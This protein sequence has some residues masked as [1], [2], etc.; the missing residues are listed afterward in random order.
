M[1]TAAFIIHKA[2]KT[3]LSIDGLVEKW[4]V[5]SR[6]PLLSEDRARL[7]KLS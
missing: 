6:F 2:E 1:F 4:K 7:R 5:E 3:Q